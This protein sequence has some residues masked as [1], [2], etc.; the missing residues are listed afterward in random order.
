MKRYWW[1]GLLGVILT[2]SLLGATWPDAARHN[3]AP[4]TAPGPTAEVDAG[5]VVSHSIQLVVTGSPAVCAYRLQG[6][7][8][9]N[10]GRWYN[11]SSDA[12]PCTADTVSFEANK[13]TRYV[14]GYLLTLTGGQSPSVALYYVGK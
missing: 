8:S 7:N 10:A 2:L 14:R 11:I 13:P 6:S 1:P 12:I 9:A 4:Q 5:A 3:F